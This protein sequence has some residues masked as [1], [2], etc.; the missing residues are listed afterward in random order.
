MSPM[1]PVVKRDVGLEPVIMQNHGKKVCQTAEEN[2]R[3]VQVSAW[4]QM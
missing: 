4:V 1:M 3:E 2:L